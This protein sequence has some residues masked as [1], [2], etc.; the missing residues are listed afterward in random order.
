[1]S[2]DEAA[3]AIASVSSVDTQPVI[4]HLV[5]F[6]LN[7]THAMPGVINFAKSYNVK[8]HNKGTSGLSDDSFDCVSK[9]LH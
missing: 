2:D 7:L 9:Y 8:L 1:M 6:A 4:P 5:P 3:S